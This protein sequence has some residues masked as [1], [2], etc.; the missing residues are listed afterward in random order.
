MFKDDF[1]RLV[2]ED[3]YVEFITKIIHEAE[4]P[5]YIERDHFE[6][7]LFS[8]GSILKDFLFH[9]V[10]TINEYKKIEEELQPFVLE[11]SLTII[12]KLYYNFMTNFQQAFEGYIDFEIYDSSMEFIKKISLLKNLSENEVLTLLSN[13]QDDFGEKVDGL[14]SREYI[15]RIINHEEILF[16]IE[17]QDRENI[18]SVNKNVTTDNGLIIA[19]YYFFII[20]FAMLHSLEVFSKVFIPNY[21]ILETGLENFDL[22]PLIQDIALEFFERP[23]K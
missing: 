8:C 5:K 15:M 10:F 12:L 13:Y 21:Q 2:F 19:K 9:Y 11:A 6:R 17:N 18:L 3:G 7:S 23:M 4:E 22:M 14:F 20:F 1:N 16:Q